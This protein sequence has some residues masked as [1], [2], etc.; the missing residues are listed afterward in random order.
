M[1]RQRGVS[2][3][4]FAIV[5]CIFGVL[6]LVFL[7][8]MERVQGD[9]ERT[10]VQLTIRN[11][12]LGMQL[13][14]GELM[15]RGEEQ[16]MGDLVA[17]NPIRFLEKQPPGY[18]GEVTSPDRRGGW[19]FDPIRKEIAYRPRLPQAFEGRDELRWRYQSVAFAA[20][21]LGGLRLVAI[22]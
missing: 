21:R 13:A 15:M 9:A 20:D 16:R 4:E 8:R 7:E 22:E 14:V 11:M 5:V 1:K 12:R 19:V 18:E 6:A 2:Q 10:E 3:F 17:A